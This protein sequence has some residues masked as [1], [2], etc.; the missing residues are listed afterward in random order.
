[1]TMAGQ[2][3]RPRN[4]NTGTVGAPPSARGRSPARARRVRGAVGVLVALAGWAAVTQAGLV[5]PTDLPT[6]PAVAGA[7]GESWPALAASLGTTLTALFVGLAV[8]SVAGLVLGVLVGLSR[9]A[10]AAT[11]LL[12]RM[13][14]P[15]PSLALI[16]I[17]ILLA[18]LGLAMTAGLVSFAAFWPVFI[19]TRYA[20]HSI[21][22]RYRDTARSLGMGRWELVWR[23]VLPS[24]APSVATGIR[25]AAGVAIVVT[26]SVE[27]VAGTGGL[28]GFVLSAEQGGA[29]AQLYAG[30]V[31]GG[32]VGWLLNVALLALTRRLLP[33][34]AA[35]EQR[36]ERR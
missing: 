5:S 31:V 36:G 6:V 30:L 25:I 18:G 28:G 22:P 24:V 7:L 27:L 34:Q 1:M 26:I 14:R 33:W 15:L 8:A 21:D 23:V 19:N 13:M 9:W 16:P 11:D 10:D 4:R 35:A 3:T 32:V 12:V 2:P 17:A 20:A 29:T